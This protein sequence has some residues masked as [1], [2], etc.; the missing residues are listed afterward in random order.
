MKMIMPQSWINPLY[1]S[2]CC[3]AAT[4]MYFPAASHA[5]NLTLDTYL[6]QVFES[7]EELKAIE[8]DIKSLQLEINVRELELSPIIAAQMVKFWDD[9]PS[10]SS[11]Q[12]STGIVT[13]VELSKPF[14]SGTSLNM[15]SGIE[16]AEYRSTPQDEQNL[17]NWKLGVTQSL[18]QNS[19][20]HQTR[21]RRQRDD[22]ELKSR[23]LTL[24]KD[25]Q[26][27]V[28]ELE[29]L[30][31]DIAYTNAEVKIR[32]ENLER[33]RRI[34]SWIQERYDRSATEY[35][36]LLQGKTLVTSRELQLQLS[37]D[38]LKTFQAR[39]NERVLMKEA[40]NPSEEDLKQERAIFL[41]PENI[42]FAPKVPVL[43]ESLQSQAQVD[44]LKATAK[45]ESD[46]LKP[47][48]ELGYAYGQQGLSTSFSRARDQAFSRKNNYH[49]VGVVFAMP[50]DFSLISKSR[51]Y[52]EA[53][54]E[55]EQWRL[56]KFRRQSVIQWEDLIRT[57]DEQKQRVDTAVNLAK[58]QNDKA[59]EERERY[60]KGKTTA[61]SAISFEQEAAESDLLVLQ[62]LTKL[63][64]TEAQARL[65][66]Q[67]GGV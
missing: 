45:F 23:L 48:L 19:F 54:A 41:L 24:I 16:T 2:L 18:W 63:R 13:E 27:I 46:K 22:N 52:R 61:F 43:I 1:F 28:I 58:L 51:R 3:A 35:V 4:L 62:L 20:G 17:L 26:D 37:V 64:R 12:Q 15:T 42:G 21:L 31:W 34:L 39:F 9:R 14:A 56:T 32:K 7:S 57:I 47:T 66:V 65:Y 25:K 40:I 36:D 44:Y 29:E 59:Q 11:S 33:S 38:N 10:L 8:E 49:E 60:E 30:Y 53:A 55:A 67:G 50:L 5:Q 6:A